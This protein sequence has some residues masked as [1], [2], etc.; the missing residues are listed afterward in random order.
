MTKQYFR[1]A[2]IIL[3]LTLLNTTA[4]WSKNM[5]IWSEIV[6]LELRKKRVSYILYK[7]VMTNNMQLVLLLKDH[8]DGGIDE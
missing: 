5:A 3:I 6:I 4:I 1:G 2:L 7:L 8:Y